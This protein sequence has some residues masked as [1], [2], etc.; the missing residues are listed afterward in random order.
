MSETA[1]TPGSASVPTER[2]RELAPEDV[3]H[4]GHPVTVGR[5][6]AGARANHWLT[7][8]C[9]I[10]L[11]V[12]G[13]ALFHPDLFFLTGLFG[14]G[15]NTRAIHPWIGV[16]L[17]FSFA[18]LVLRFWR[19]NL[20]NKVDTQWVA[21]AKDV[22]SGHEERL[23]DVPRY[24][25]GQKVIFWGMTLL[26]MTLIVTGLMIWQQYFDTYTSMPTKRVAIFV[27]SMAGI[28]IISIWILHVYASIW[29]R[30]TMR[31]MTRGTVT[32]GWAWRHHR[33]WLKAIVER[34]RV[35]PPSPK[36]PAE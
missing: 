21:Q 10:L 34:Q 2:D 31:A 17:F 5:Y 3:I 20:W 9:L 1:K 36:A 22:L 7:A 14:G 27:H 16:V 30:G 33:R 26:I 13:L 15:Q 24:N 35:R 25:A 8:L 12:S 23:P 19:A 6:S 29:I 11:A 18:G 32:G 4:P 28:F